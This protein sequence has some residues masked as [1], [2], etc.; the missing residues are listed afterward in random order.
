MNASTKKIDLV[1]PPT[2]PDALAFCPE[3][4]N[5]VM[6][7]INKTG[8]RPGETGYRLATIATMA[9]DTRLIYAAN[10]YADD[11]ALASGAR[12][13]RLG[14]GA[15]GDY[16]ASAGGYTQT[17]L[18]AVTRL[19]EAQQALGQWHAALVFDVVIDCVTARELGRRW[20]QDDK[21][22]ARH[23]VKALDKLA[24][25]YERPSRKNVIRRDATA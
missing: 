25:W 12:G 9:G 10:Q 5:H 2:N 4:L 3:L 21:Q 13:E 6:V 23:A 19:R 7:E 1:K 22:A 18:D 8:F 11:Y 24:E 15:T 16:V 14:T 17:Q 20:K